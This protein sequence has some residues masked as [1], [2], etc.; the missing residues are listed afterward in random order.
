VP[1]E[2][3]V[4]RSLG[5]HQVPE[6]LRAAGYVVRTLFDVY[7]EAEE[8]LADTEFLRDAGRRG[9]VVLTRDAAIRRRPH[10]LRVVREEWVKIF[11]LSRGNLKGAEQ[12]ARFIDNLDRI[13]RACEQPGPFI[14]AVLAG[15]LELRFPRGEATGSTDD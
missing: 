7:G 1:P 4:D 12:V 8:R 3:L 6:A 2:F 5:R 15:G 14:Y 9:W 11:E 13:V 10:E